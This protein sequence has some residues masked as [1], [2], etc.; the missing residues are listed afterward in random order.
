M[1]RCLYA[2]DLLGPH[3]PSITGTIRMSQSV[4]NWLLGLGMALAL[5]LS[6]YAFL[7]L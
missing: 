7:Q 1:V 2:R 5:V 3:Q 6:D 4:C